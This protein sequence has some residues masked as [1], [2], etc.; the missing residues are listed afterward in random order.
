M[1][2]PHHTSI[3][4]GKFDQLDG[5]IVSRITR[6]PCTFTELQGKGLRDAADA[7]V[8]ADR[9]GFKEG[10]RLI[11][12]RLQALRKAGRIVYSKGRWWLKGTE[13]LV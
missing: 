1:T 5:L 10:S 4:A 12:R 7:L 9:H 3:N 6:A 11:D 2:T 8:K 13:V